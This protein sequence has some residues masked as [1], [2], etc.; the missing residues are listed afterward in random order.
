MSVK[1]ITEGSAVSPEERELRESASTGLDMSP[2]CSSCKWAVK[3]IDRLR[4]LFNLVNEYATMQHKFIVKHFP[5][6]VQDA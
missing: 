2:G 6:E 1:C 3:E 5:E 4:K